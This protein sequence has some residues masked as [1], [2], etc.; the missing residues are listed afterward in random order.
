M[1]DDMMCF[2]G[3]EFTEVSHVLPHAEQ[4]QRLTTFPVGKRVDVEGAM[5]T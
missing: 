3:G 1:T 4:C 2:L 5:T